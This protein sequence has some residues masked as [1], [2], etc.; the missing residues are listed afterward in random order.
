MP[1]ALFAR[2]LF[3]ALVHGRGDQGG[4]QL[5]RTA[6]IVEAPV[7]ELADIDVPEDLGGVSE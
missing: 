1:P 6:S 3:D 2:S 7:P 5:L 4:R